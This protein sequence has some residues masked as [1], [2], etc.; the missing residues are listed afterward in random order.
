LP[1]EL[2]TLEVLRI[3]GC[4]QVGFLHAKALGKVGLI[5]V[6]IASLN[7]PC[8]NAQSQYSGHFRDTSNEV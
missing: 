3:G 4:E 8:S 7:L 5:L 6:Q 2:E 1:I